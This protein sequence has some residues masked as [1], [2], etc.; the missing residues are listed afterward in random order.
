MG[1]ASFA[2]ATL[3]QDPASNLRKC[4]LNGTEKSA[5]APHTR[6]GDETAPVS[7]TGPLVTREHRDRVASY[8]GA[9]AARPWFAWI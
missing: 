1:V 2:L 6:I 4:I 9:L 3:S 8:A 5:Y 7:E